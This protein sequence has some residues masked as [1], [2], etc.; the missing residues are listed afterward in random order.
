MAFHLRTDKTIG[1][2]IATILNIFAIIL[3]IIFV[4]NSEVR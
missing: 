1:E 3:A 4:W 2:F